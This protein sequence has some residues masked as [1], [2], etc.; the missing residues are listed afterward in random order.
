MRRLK[1][2]DHVTSLGRAGAGQSP[3]RNQSNR[4]DPRMSDETYNGWKNYATWGVALVLDN[5]EGTYNHVR[6][7]VADV[8]HYVRHE[9]PNVPEIWSIERALVFR[10]ADRLKDYTRGAKTEEGARK[11]RREISH[12]PNVV[13][14]DQAE[15][16]NL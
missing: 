9:D 1:V 10:L 14:Y 13:I 12:W 7:M 3:D 8:G 11:A 16:R 2:G 6:E 15:D 4:K 5:D